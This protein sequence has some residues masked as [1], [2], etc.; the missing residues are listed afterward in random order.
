MNDQKF[1]HNV[2][3]LLFLILSY[4]IPPHGINCVFGLLFAISAVVEFGIGIWLDIKMRRK[5]D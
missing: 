2:R 4:V 1:K 5:N 3:G